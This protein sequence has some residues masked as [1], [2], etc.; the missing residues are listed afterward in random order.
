LTVNFQRLQ[1]VRFQCIK[2]SGFRPEHHFTITALR[3]YN[4]S[5]NHAQS[6]VD[7]YTLMNH[8]SFSEHLQ[9]LK[10]SIHLYGPVNASAILTQASF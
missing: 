8:N 9:R 2:S 5:Q 6:K 7:K 1:H 3:Y 10:F 4:V